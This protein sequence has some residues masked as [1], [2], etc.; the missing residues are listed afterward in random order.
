MN[1]RTRLGDELAKRRA[2]NTRYSLRAFARDLG[3][4]HTTVARALDP[5]H[6]ITQNTARRVGRTL[7]LS[8]AEVQAACLNA[9]AE[10]LA[11]CL[12]TH[13]IMP[14]SRSLAVLT[15]MSIDD[16]N[17]ALTHLLYQRHVTMH[18]TSSWNLTSP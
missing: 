11:R 9:N 10:W 15:S 6:R 17:V 5:A 13:W 3:M 7:K 2:R 12:R 4:H 8:T 16:V 14:N 18:S 1:L